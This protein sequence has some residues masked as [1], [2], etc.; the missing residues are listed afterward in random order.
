M[1]KDIILY[2]H[3]ERAY[4]KLSEMLKITNYCTI[5][6]ATGTGK[7]FIVL[8]YLYSNRNKRILY[9]SPSYAIND[10]LVNEHFQELGISRDDF[11]KFDT[12]I[13]TSLLK[14]NMKELESQYDI[15]ILDEY[16]RCG[17]YEWGK[18][19]NQLMSYIKKNNKI[20]I[21]T[22]ATPVRYLD[23]NRNMCDI[24]FDGHVA[25]ELSVADAMIE[26]ILP[27]PYYIN[28]SLDLLEQIM[29]L[30]NR[31]VKNIPYEELQHHYLNLLDE[32]EKK[33][34]TIGNDSDEVVKDKIISN[35]KYL[36][37]SN[38][39]SNMNK[40]IKTIKSAFDLDTVLYYSVSA[41]NSHDINNEIIREFRTIE[42]KVPTFLSSVNIAN[43]GLHIKGLDAIFLLRKT[44]SPIIYL[45]Q[46]GRLLSFS[47]NKNQLYI[48]DL[49][50]NATNNRVITDLY[51]ELFD[52]ARIKI[53]ENPDNKDRYQKIIDC[54]KIVDI[55][56]KLAIEIENLTKQLTRSKMIELRLDYAIDI[57]G[58][59][60]Y[61]DFDYDK[62]QA[63]LDIF[64]YQKYINRD[65]F[66]RLSVL[67]IDKPSLFNNTFAQFDRYLG[68]CNSIQEVLSSK[69]KS[70]VQ[71]IYDFYGFVYH[72]PRLFSSDEYERE[73]ATSMMTEFETYNDRVRNFIINHIEDDFCPLEK[74]IYLSQYD[75]EHLNSI[76]LEISKL[77]EENRPVSIEI[78]EFLDNQTDLE[79]SD[80]LEKIKVKR[81]VFHLP[82]NEVNYPLDDIKDNELIKEK[83][84]I[85]SDIL[86]KENTFIEIRNWM[87]KNQF[88]NKKDFLSNLYNSLVFFVNQNGSLPLYKKKDEHEQELF[89]QYY[90]FYK[91]L[92]EEG[93]IQKIDDLLNEINLKVIEKR[94]Q[95][96]LLNL[97]LFLDDHDG[98]LPCKESYNP[99]EQQ[100]ALDYE[101][102]SD[103]FTENERNS[104][105]Q[106]QLGLELRKNITI[107]S[108]VNFIKDKGRKPLLSN[109]NEK[110]YD[111]ALDFLRIKPFLKEEELLVIETASSKLNKYDEQKR[112]LREMLNEKGRK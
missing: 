37:F 93:Y 92:K 44:S 33:F 103:L 108:Y 51:S 38:N 29:K 107:K 82:I 75:L 25:S 53:V 111:L 28:Y 56:G 47:K 50:G 2:P 86:L 77:I 21:G 5:N 110:E 22:S 91:Q 101:L 99:E 62:L 23:H 94:K 31:I 52:K 80:L 71:D 14:M 88:P 109:K 95:D 43:E 54:F 4:V 6:H 35:G 26:G 39:I 32:L 10:Q 70:R 57:L 73:L 84:N 27:V 55:T 104:I 89:V 76:Y 11:L 15:V 97:I 48:F 112:L 60:H 79:S 40:D 17:A 45:Q 69:F 3:N 19:V 63:Q 24:L 68:D 85:S 72:L 64:K 18:K 81:E 36:I 13:Y 58:S 1:E 20:C 61:G 49:V 78:V 30:K 90:I 59:D 65:Q 66:K 8:K 105:N 42:N 106:H 87:K 41:V 96:F 34:S 67:S 74:L 98:C 102:F 100:L 16:Q 83:Y 9:L 12:L 46:I 7:S